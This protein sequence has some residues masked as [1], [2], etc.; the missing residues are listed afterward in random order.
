MPHEPRPSLAVRVAPVL[1]ATALVIWGIIL[2]V[3]V[4]RFHRKPTSNSVFQVF[5]DAGQRW[6]QGISPY[7]IP[8]KDFRYSPVL[9]AFFAPF[10]HLSM[11]W[12]SLAW[13]LVNLGVFFGGAWYF[14][15]TVLAKLDV[16]NDHPGYAATL[17]LLATPMLVGNFSNLQSNPVVLGTLLAAVAACVERRFTL[18][19]LAIGV[20][21]FLKIYPLSLGLLLVLL[22]PKRLS[23]RLLGVL[24]LGLLLPYATK[25]F[26][27]AFVTRSYDEWLALLKSDD[28]KYFPEWDKYKDFSLMYHMW[29]EPFWGPMTASVTRGIFGGTVLG[30]AAG[31]LLVR[32]R[33]S[34]PQLDS[35]LAALCLVLFLTLAWMMLW[36]PATESSTY[37]FVAPIS[38][39]L[40]LEC[41]LGRMSPLACIL[42]ITAFALLTFSAFC[43]W[44]PLGL[45]L[46]P[47]RAAL[48]VLVQLAR[49][50]VGDLLPGLRL[51]VRLAARDLELLDPGVIPPMPKLERSVI[52]SYFW[53]MYHRLLDI[54]VRYEIAYHAA[55][56]YHSH[57]MRNHSR[58]PE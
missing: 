43:A 32:R 28:R 38:A 41:I 47:C 50:P 13:L 49:R 26:D 23:W 44:H 52:D 54:G 1:P 53:R 12:G 25:P 37:M 22:F 58:I 42:P 14:V 56:V 33:L 3:L 8:D 9:A 39:F 27:A 31:T 18:A 45:Y 16:G 10:A 34:R 7:K 29:L 2:V 21:T 15:R 19:A 55:H 40:L 46:R 11:F 57:A 6:A 48:L 51:H 36:G 35:A 5:H 30:L 17:L 20:A 24:A 4:V